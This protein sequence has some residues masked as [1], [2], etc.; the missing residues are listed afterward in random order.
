MES[1]VIISYSFYSKPRSKG[2]FEN[3]ADL[4]LNACD[5]GFP[6]PH[7]HTVLSFSW[8]RKGLWMQLLP[9]SA[10]SAFDVFIWIFCLYSTWLHQVSRALEVCAPLMTREGHEV[11]AATWSLGR[12]WVQVL[13][14]LYHTGCTS[15]GPGLSTEGPL[16]Q[17]Y[18]HVANSV[19]LSSCYVPGAGHTDCAPSS[20]KSQGHWALV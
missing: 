6:P 3:I 5:V 12:H 16:S 9:G 13:Q 7:T 11:S 2:G 18:T 1:E 20:C 17:L 8:P 4:P 10:S 14:S 19:R 15:E